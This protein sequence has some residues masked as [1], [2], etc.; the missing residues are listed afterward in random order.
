MRTHALIALLGAPLLAGCSSGESGAQTPDSAHLEP[1]APGAGVQYRMVSTVA[2]GQEIE[3]CKLIVAPPEGLTVRADEV[4]FSAG[5]HHVVLY[6]TAYKEIPAETRE[7]VRVD[8]AEVHDCNNGATA[9]WEIT[10]VVAG[11]QSFGGESFLGDLP[12][13]VALKVEPG[14]VLVM[15]THYLNASPEPLVADARVNLYTMPP[16]QVEQEAGMLFHYNPFIRVPA[17]GAASARMRCR[18]D[19]DI[20]IVRVQSHMHRRGVGFAAHRVRGDGAMEEIYANEA[21]EEV[22]AKVFPSPLEVKAGEA[23]DFRCDYVN[24]EPRDVVQGLT[25]RDEMCMLIGPYFPRSPEIDNCTDAQGVPAETWIGSGAATCA[26]TLACASAAASDAALYGCVVD[27]CP[28]A[29]A[30]VSGALR[31][32]FLTAGQGACADACA[33]DADRC[34]ACVDEACAADVTA[35]QAA[36]C[37]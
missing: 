34:A 22:P 29:A 23:L 12:D 7:G 21:W 11:S 1:P 28:G 14:A 13:G 15:N 37:D 33:G 26:E 5:S 6:K 4:R 27:S 32:Q 35:C 36:A 9:A 30:Q 25:T 20:S 2:P 8:A 17:N 10:G 16:E 31:C 19:E 24:A 3:R 18:I